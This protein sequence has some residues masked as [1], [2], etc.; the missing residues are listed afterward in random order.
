MSTT[1]HMPPLTRADESPSAIE[2]TEEALSLAGV[3]AV[4]TIR[5]VEL[6]AIA[7]AALLFVPPLAI[8]VVVVVVPLI[9]LTALVAL[10]ATIVA[11]PVYLVR[12]V[13]R[14]RAAHA[15]HVVR[16]LAD[17]GRSEQALATSRVRRVVARAQ[18]K[19][20]AKPTP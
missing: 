6:V 16:R 13:H 10:V 12:H 20:Y 15:H 14:H 4:G 18:R 7:V 1:E 11:V 9:V 5:V 2:R 8:L 17:L 3:A 19:L